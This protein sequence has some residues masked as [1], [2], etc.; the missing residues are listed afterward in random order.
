MER[1]LLLIACLISGYYFT[2]LRAQDTLPRLERGSV[3]PGFIITNDGDTIKGYILNINL[4]LNQ[5]MT[6]YYSDPEDRA[7][8]VKYKPKEIKAYQVGPSYYESMKYSFPYKARK[9][10]FV[11]RKFNGPVEL[12]VWYYNPDKAN[13]MDPDITLDDLEKSLV[14][15]EEDLSASYYAVKDGGE[16]TELTSFKF[17]LKF[18][19]NMSEYV[20]D[21]PELAKKISDKT[22]GYL[23]IPRDIERIILE[24]NRHIGN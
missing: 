12:Y 1:K 23:G 7:G 17:L 4:L 14:Y 11:L 16:F 20:G 3:H 24:Y 6:F 5:N 13:L 18:A 9:E 8:R 10:S 19:R 22:E 2:P 15:E 21:D